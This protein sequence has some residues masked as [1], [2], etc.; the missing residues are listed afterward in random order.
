MIWLAT[1]G[2]IEMKDEVLSFD[3]FCA[4]GTTTGVLCEIGRGAM[5]LVP[6]K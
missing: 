1:S 6:A 2:S 4:I 5:F 3:D